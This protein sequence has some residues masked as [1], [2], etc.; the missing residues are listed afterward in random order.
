MVECQKLIGLI[1][2]IAPPLIQEEWDNSGFQIGDRYSMIGKVMV[3]LDLTEQVAI[4]AASAGAGMVLTHHPAFFRPVK[5]LTTD[6]DTGRAILTL[7]R[8]GIALYCAHTSWDNAPNGLN[9]ALAEAVGLRDIRRLS[10]QGALKKVVVFVP[11]G[12]E[13]D[14]ATAMCDAGAGKIGRYS[15]CT[16][17]A[18]GTGTFRPE[19][20]AK[21]FIGSGG[22]L[23]KTKETRLETIV[24]EYLLGAVVAA[25]LEAHPYEEA[26]YDIYNVERPG[27][28]SSGRLGELDTPMEFDEL[29]REMVA[30]FGRLRASGSEAA[31]VEKVAVCGGAGAS[32]ME[33][34]SRMGADVLITGDVRHH[35]ALMAAGAGLLLIDAGHYATE[36]IGVDALTK[37]LQRLA[38][39][40]QYSVEFI[41]SAAEKDPWRFY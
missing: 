39:E 10:S 13:D 34:A 23:E 12:Y 38:F 16:F 37:R 22:V 19:E 15:D 27:T 21:P 7:N 28:I 4:E 3:A 5:S 14:I 41:R 11:S 20:A 32:V 8:Y 24:D 25:M 9:D 40:L 29:C 2:S 6:D 1:E 18:E 36:R 17:R 33:A 30:V 31:L 26:A 35:E